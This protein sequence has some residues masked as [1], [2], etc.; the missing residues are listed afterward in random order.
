M[1]YDSLGKQTATLWRFTGSGALDT[2]FGSGTGIVQTS[3]PVEDGTTRW[4]DDFHAMAID[5]TSRILAVGTSDFYL[6]PGDSSTIEYRVVLA[7]YD[8]NGVPDPSFGTDGSGRVWAPRVFG[9]DAPHAVTVQGDDRILVAGETYTPQNSQQQGVL[10]RLH[11]EGSSDTDFGTGGWI[12]DLIVGAR[13]GAYWNGM[14]LQSDGRIVCGGGFTVDL[15]DGT[16][17]SYIALARFWQ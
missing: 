11:S 12:I 13:R 17:F 7:R 16:A 9:K 1:S 3:F 8:Q 10:W 6:V 14:K 5:N 4:G 15:P 2:S